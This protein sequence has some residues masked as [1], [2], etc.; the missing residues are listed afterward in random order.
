VGV[1]LGIGRCD[2]SE[3]DVFASDQPVMNRVPIPPDQ[4]MYGWVPVR[5]ERIVGGYLCEH[6]TEPTALWF[7]ERTGWREVS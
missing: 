7:L 5:D 3:P 2:Q 4:K 1:P 6:P